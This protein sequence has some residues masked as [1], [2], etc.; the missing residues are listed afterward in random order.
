MV[1]GAWWAAVHRVTQSWTRLKWLSM[2]AHTGEGN[3]NPLQYSCWRIPEPGGLPSIGS[4]SQTRLKRLSS[5]ISSQQVAKVLEL[6]HQSFQWI[7][8]I[9]FLKFKIYWFDLLEVQ[10]TLK[11]SPTP[12]L[13]SINSLAFSLLYG[14]TLT[15]IHDYWKNHSFDH[16]CKVMPLLFKCCLGLS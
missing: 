16:C 4:H 8:R 2:H 10:G 14:P 7:F 15:S 12:Q 1:R 9:D 6:Q 5:S 11:S 3:D 13:K